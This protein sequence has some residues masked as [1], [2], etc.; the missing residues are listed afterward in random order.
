MTEELTEDISDHFPVVISLTVRVPGSVAIP[1]GGDANAETEGGKNNGEFKE[2]AWR[3]I[4]H[5]RRTIV[6]YAAPYMTILCGRW[7]E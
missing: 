4:L 7:C 2:P 5:A 6:T 1:P 3:L